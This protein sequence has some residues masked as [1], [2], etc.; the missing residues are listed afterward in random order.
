MQSFH[1]PSENAMKQKSESIPEAMR[2]AHD[3]IVRV[4]DDVCA[5]HLNDEYK[6]LAH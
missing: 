1:K 3:P 2:A 4:I 5:K 6:T